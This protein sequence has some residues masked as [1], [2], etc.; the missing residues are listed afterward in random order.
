MTRRVRART[1]THMHTRTCRGRAWSFGT[2][3]AVACMHLGSD[4][5]CPAAVDLAG[6]RAPH[7]THLWRCVRAC[8]PHRGCRSLTGASEDIVAALVCQMFEGIRD[9]LVQV[10]GGGELGADGS[11]ILCCVV[12]CLGLPGP[13]RLLRH[14]ATSPARLPPQRLPRPCRGNAMQQEPLSRACAL[15]QPLSAGLLDGWGARCRPPSSS[16]TA[17]S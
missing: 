15:L 3:L 11:A 2:R 1:R 17:S 8:V 5:F 9:H 12:L 14:G 10:G 16:S 6:M 4:S 13:A 7:S